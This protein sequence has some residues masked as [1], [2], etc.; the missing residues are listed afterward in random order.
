MLGNRRVCITCVQDRRVKL[1]GIPWE[2]RRSLGILTAW[3][4]T[5]ADSWLR[6]QSFYSRID[7]GG[8]VGEA[9]L[10]MILS[11][12]WISL[13]WLGLGLVASLL[14]GAAVMLDG[15]A[16]D[17]GAIAG[18][19]L[20]VFAFYGVLIPIG[21]LIFVLISTL[22]SH[23]VLRL[24]GGGAGG[25]GA[26]MR[27]TLYSGGIYMFNGVPC[28]NYIVWV[29]WSILHVIGFMTLHDEPPLRPILAVLAPFALCCGCAIGYYI[30][31]LSITSGNF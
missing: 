7:P 20:A 4:R 28:L 29:W 10:Y 8:L 2:E 31:M 3:F 19:M 21:N 22:L 30:F 6:P 9:M 14:V 1:Y 13:F 24:L 15:G 16:A 18:V 27:T 12:A 17:G 26:S 5:T 25:L 23:L 11:L